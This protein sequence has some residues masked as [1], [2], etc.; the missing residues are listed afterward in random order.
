MEGLRSRLR[1]PGGS[2]LHLEDI[3]DIE[4]LQTS[5]LSSGGG[6]V[7]I[8]E[9]YL[10]HLFNDFSFSGTAPLDAALEWARANR[11]HLAGSLVTALDGIDGRS[12][13][14]LWIDLDGWPE[15]KRIIEAYATALVDAANRKPGTPSRESARRVRLDGAHIA[16]WLDGRIAEARERIRACEGLLES[17][18]KLPPDAADAEVPWDL[19]V[20]YG[21]SAGWSLPTAAQWEKAFRGADDRR[22]P[23]GNVSIPGE[24]NVGVPYTGPRSMER[25]RTGGEHSP[26]GVWSMAGNVSECVFPPPSLQDAGYHFLKGGN[27]YYPEVYADAG[28]II[29][30]VR[31]NRSDL[32]GFRVVRELRSGEP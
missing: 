7:H 13:A 17:L 30:A 25:Y 28:C 16:G 18:G 5:G 22:Y 11:E 32:G 27:W 6:R 2:R 9:A 1:G 10:T 31:M 19:R 29:A 12:K 20:E 3:P 26:Y 23:W 15:G 8:L 21:R 4:I 24:A 14:D